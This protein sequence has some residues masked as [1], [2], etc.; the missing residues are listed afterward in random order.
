MRAPTSLLVRL[1]ATL[2]VLFGATILSAALAQ[3][4]AP[5][6]S[7]SD[8]DA[9]PI[10]TSI[11]T[12][13]PS[14]FKRGSKGHASKKSVVANSLGHSGG[15]HRNLLR[16]NG[17]RQKFDR[18]T[19]PA[20]PRRPQRNSAEG[21]RAGRPRGHVQECNSGG[22]WRKGNHRNRQSPSRIYSA[23]DRWVHTARPAT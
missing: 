9:N 18:A 13:P 22:K 7:Q 5:A 20:G 16:A 15:H 10:D 6:A 11:T 14:H 4:A 3:D 19:R 1:F 8:A 12:Q 17:R 23:P 2:F 21:L